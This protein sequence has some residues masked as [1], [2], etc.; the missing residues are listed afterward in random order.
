[1]SRPNEV[2]AE[3]SPDELDS[4]ADSERT[5]VPREMF[6][7]FA[8]VNVAVTNLAVGALGIVLGLS[9]VDVLLVYFLGAILGSAAVGL[10]ALQGQRT[11]G[12]VMVNARPSFGFEGA[13]LLAVLLF[14]TT[15]GWFG[16]NSYFGV[17]AARSMAAQFGVP[18]GPGTD[19]L[20]LALLTALLVLVAVFGYRI[21][22]KYERIAF[23][24]M[25]ISLVIVAIGA[26]SGGIDWGHQATVHGAERIG[27][28]TVLVTALGVGWGVS[29]T[30]FAHDFGRFVRRD[31][32]QRKVFF[33]AAVGMYVGTFLTFALSAVIAISAESSLDVGKTVEAALPQAVAFP[34]LLVMTL[35][36]LPANLVNLFVGPA[37]L[38][39]A[40][41]RLNRFQGV[42]ITALVG[43]P[44]AVAGI[45]QPEFGST[46]KAFML[47]L[48]MWLTP[49]LVI[50]LSDYF[51][52][53]RGYYT[54]VELF[55]RHGVAGRFFAPGIVA[56]VV[57]LAASLA[58]ANT[59]IF[60][61]PLM[62]RY[63]GGADL[64]LFVGALVSFAV[65]YP[66]ASSRKKASLR[67]E[68]PAPEV[69]H[70][71]RVAEPEP[72]P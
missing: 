54:D 49:W 15:A 4:T 29:W 28:I 62:T 42:L 20:L 30:P 36:L 37:V 40:G 8:G 66:W 53:H 65:Y 22:T 48:V 33:S 31:A 23:I 13:R 18:G 2:P 9:L 61:S 51:L 32:S 56:W 16:V 64:S 21:I 60:A 26:F 10:C 72:T 19:V 38:K 71:E 1:M 3:P 52:I 12:S 5:G 34:V 50:T 55:T 67:S 47:T 46:F 35:G 17:T 70:H 45:Y 7:V 14:I 43:M 69:V 58:F 41:L 57:G 11:G 27:A 24:G 59:P 6:F 39:T 44:I 25:G 68:T 63:F